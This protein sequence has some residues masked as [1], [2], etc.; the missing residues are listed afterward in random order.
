MQ[1]FELD[2]NRFGL[3]IHRGVVSELNLSEVRKYISSQQ[4]DILILRVDSRLKEQHSTL[5]SLG[6]PVL[7]CDTLVYYEVD[8]E[9]Y[10]PNTLKNS[11]EFELVDSK[12]R[13]LLGG[14][15][16]RIFQE[17]KNHY[18]SNPYLDKT[19]IID[20]YVEWAQNYVLTENPG[21]ISWIVRD[22]NKDV[23]G[24][25]TCS[26]DESNGTCEGVLY[27]ILPEKSGGG[28]YG[29][30]IRFTQ[31]YFRQL[32]FKKMLVSTQVQNYAVQKVW[33]REGFYMNKSY[34]TYHVNAFLA[35]DKKS[36]E[37]TLKIT[38][39]DI[40]KFGSFSGDMNPVH[41][42]DDYAVSLGFKGRIAHGIRFE[43]ALTHVLGT[44]WP[45]PGTIILNTKVLYNSPVYP[46][47]TY[48]IVMKK[49]QEKSNGAVEIVAL[50]KDDQN[51]LIHVAYVNVLKK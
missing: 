22:L 5:F 21:R 28:V 30:L 14:L 7:H 24:F 34:D 39:Q 10:N 46:D 51:R 41:Y 29:D 23:L 27:G 17:Y 6:Y 1:F 49:I 20:G 31:A 18:T 37:T 4:L 8:F 45:G 40:E 2:S 35:E 50:L 9:K 43:M 19:G 26:F 36:F 3:N 12:N 25:A 42:N 13:E 48:R 15:V 47:V 16:P 44:Q 32:G 38:E 11:L 33:A